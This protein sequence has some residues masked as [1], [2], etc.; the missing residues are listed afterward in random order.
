[1]SI[2]K[3]H[4]HV[5]PNTDGSLARCGGPGLCAQCSQEVAEKYG[6]HRIVPFNVL[7]RFR[8]PSDLLAYLQGWRDVNQG[9][10]S[11]ISH[12]DLQRLVATIFEAL[13]RLAEAS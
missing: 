12:E 7:E 11:D 8:A 5:T 6:R 13:A 10:A 2:T 9:D 1:M 3:S 4:G